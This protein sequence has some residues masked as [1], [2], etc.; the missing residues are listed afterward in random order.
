MKEALEKLWY[1]YLWE[2]CSAIDTEE[3]RT[4]AQRTVALHK[5][6]VALLSKEQED[7]LEKYVDALCGV[8]ALFAKKAF[9]K[10]CEFTL[11]FLWDVGH[12]GE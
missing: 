5:E 7:A 6:A 4:L 8:E 3:A 2:E 12:A 10:G 9:L 11:A 1:E